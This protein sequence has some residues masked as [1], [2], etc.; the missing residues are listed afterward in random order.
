MTFRLAPELKWDLNETLNLYLRYDHFQ[1]LRDGNVYQSDFFR[2]GLRYRM[3]ADA[4]LAH[5]FLEPAPVP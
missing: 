5:T 3:P 1:S 2:V 4:P